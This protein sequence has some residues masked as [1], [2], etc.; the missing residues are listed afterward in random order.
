MLV[1]ARFEERVSQYTCSRT[2]VV[3]VGAGDPRQAVQVLQDGSR[4]KELTRMVLVC[5]QPRVIDHGSRIDSPVCKRLDG[6][7]V[8]RGLVVAVGMDSAGY[9]GNGGSGIHV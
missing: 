6:G 3:Q 1:C 9:V 5:S 8:D 2:P 7:R 4:V